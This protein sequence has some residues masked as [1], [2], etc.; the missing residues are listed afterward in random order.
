VKVADARTHLWST[1]FLPEL[2]LGLENLR[3]HKLRSLLTMLGMIFGVAAVVAMLSIGAGA[4]QEVMAFIEQLGVRNLIVEA[5]EAPDSQTL[6]KVRKL[7]AGL[8][9]KDL[10]VIQSNIE[11]ISAASA[12]KR[13]TPSKLMPKPLGGDTPIVYGITPAYATIANL[14]VA[15]GRFF[16]DAETSAA[17]PVAVLGEAASAALFGTDDPIGRYVKVNDQWFRVVG[18][19]GPQL[20]V[21]SDVAGI[22]AQDRNNIIYVPLY[23]S[24][25]RLEDG[26]SAQKD[27]ID[28]IY[29][30]MNQGSDITGAAAMIRGILDVAH[31]GAGDF[32]IISPAELLAEQRRT[33]RI[34]E[35]VMVAIASIS[36]LVGGIGIMN[37]M[38]ASVLERTREI[39]VRRAIGARQRDV[40]RQ[41]LIETTIISLTGGVAGILTGVGLSQLI[42]VLAG[43]STI[44][45]TSSIVLAF[46][47]SVAIGIVFGL[48]P[49]VRAS[50]LDPVKALH[51]E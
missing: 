37:I 17:A 10:R 46:G 23:S 39:G 5:R 19:A 8:S 7:S 47:V 40:V 15:T 4:Q 44:V 28:G 34:F 51:Y 14:K 9:F 43:W 32:T 42:G 41:F 36:L 6:Q 48:Y 50:R 3:A 49:A 2:R 26:Q 31:R 27:E 11:H 1:D 38:L 24:V 21:Q 35:M 30:Q 20:T 25:F 13:F 33:Q 16:D 18:V 45:T 22:P 12:R 29:L